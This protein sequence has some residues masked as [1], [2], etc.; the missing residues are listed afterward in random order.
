MENSGFKRLLYDIVKVITALSLLLLW[1]FLKPER[2]PP[3]VLIWG[4]A[5]FFLHFLEIRIP[6]FQT[7]L[8]YPL[9][10]S[11]VFSLNLTTATLISLFAPI[12]K[13]DIE[14]GKKYREA[15]FRLTDYII[16]V[17]A[18]GWVKRFL[19]SSNYSFFTWIFVPIVFFLFLFLFIFIERKLSGEESEDIP[20]DFLI[21][22][23]LGS[24]FSYLFFF[25]YLL[26]GSGGLIAFLVL[27]SVFI[28]FY[29]SFHLRQKKLLPSFL[30]LADSLDDKVLH[31]SG[32]TKLV[33]EE[34]R[35]LL[36]EYGVKDKEALWAMALFNLG[37]LPL[38]PVIKREGRLTREEFLKVKEHPLILAQALHEEGVL[39]GAREIIKHHHES[40]SGTGYPDGKVGEAI[41]LASRII[42][43]L[44]AYAAMIS[45]RPFRKAFTEEKA[46][47]EMEHFSGVQFDPDI[48]KK[49]L[50]IRGGR[51]EE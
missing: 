8:F 21:D 44:Q 24:F 10:L 45:P 32:K 26:S 43:L 40:F 47:R 34:G 28:S 9:L 35:K 36:N 37:L 22:L 15:L 4:L 30:K 7:Q 1:F 20:K 46:L 11:A 50:S 42:H 39:K 2:I 49:F 18:G 41:P 25:S 6:F 33:F 3:D 27:A 29:E 5:L 12:K 48:V 19:N 16:A 38:A 13:S 51:G 31:Q 17:Q 14:K 23:L